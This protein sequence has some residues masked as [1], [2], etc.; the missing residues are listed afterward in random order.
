MSVGS[1]FN[2]AA[3][4]GM[5]N[6]Q[7]S[8]IRWRSWWHL[9]ISS[10]LSLF[11][12]VLY[13]LVARLA[14]FLL[15]WIVCGSADL[16]VQST[17]ALD[18]TLDVHVHVWQRHSLTQQHNASYALVK[19]NVNKNEVIYTCTRA[20]ST[21]QSSGS[22][23]WLTRFFR[24]KP[25]KDARNITLLIMFLVC[26]SVGQ[27]DDPLHRQPKCGPQKEARRPANRHTTE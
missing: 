25:S 19:N 27:I 20:Q 17:W 24:I 12:S 11:N 2:A 5:S 21:R 8:W 26:H 4:C 10:F 3:N 22:K 15:I 1:G 14:R 13:Q 6:M 23:A 9:S 16:L 18:W 7:F